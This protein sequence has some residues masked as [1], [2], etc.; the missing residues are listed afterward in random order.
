[1]TDSK[2]TRK[3]KG[4]TLWLALWR[5]T[6][7]IDRLAQTDIAAHGLCASDFGML[8]ALLHRGAMRVNEIAD[9]V[10]LTSGSMTTAV[11]RLEAKG[12]VRR[13]VCD[14]DARA[15]V[16]E[17][18]ESGLALIQPAYAAHAEAIERVFAPLAEAE[19]TQLLELL[20]KL[21]HAD[22]PERSAS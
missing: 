11:D 16:V 2:T 18:T 9:V 17:L 3:P 8:E 19:R 22:R 20:L 12:L 6:R 15:R 21:R 1:M 4:V 7:D 14:R 5:V 13:S 10:L